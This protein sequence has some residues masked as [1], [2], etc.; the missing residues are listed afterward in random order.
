MTRMSMSVPATHVR[1]EVP[2]TMDSMD[3]PVPALTSGQGQPARPHSKVCACVCAVT[4]LHVYLCLYGMIKRNGLIS[5]RFAVFVQCVYCVLHLP[6]CVCVLSV[7][8]G[9]LT[10][11]AGTFSYPNTPGS[12]QYDH[13]VSCAWVIRTD[14]NKVGVI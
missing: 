7:C 13:Q 12:D 5:G 3:S 10:G 2:A 8:G 11:P 9:Y 1:T 14:V 4:A 6:V